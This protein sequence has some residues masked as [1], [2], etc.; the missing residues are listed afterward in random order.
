MTPRSTIGG[1]LDLEA[2]RLLHRPRTTAELRAACMEMHARGMGD[3]TIAMATGLAVE[4]V[5]RLLGETT[6]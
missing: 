5:R 1:T 3:H 2:L 4:Q 6:R